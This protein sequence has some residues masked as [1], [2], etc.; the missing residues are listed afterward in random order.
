MVENSGF[1]NQIS[2]LI[3][4]YKLAWKTLH[5]RPNWFMI[6]TLSVSC[7]IDLPSIEARKIH[8]DTDLRIRRDSSIGLVYFHLIEIKS[9]N[10]KDVERA[11]EGAANSDCCSTCI[12]LDFH[13]TF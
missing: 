7:L 11:R 3:I 4:V 9:Q 8:E 10:I 1:P 12:I 2:I 13:S 5:E 6:E